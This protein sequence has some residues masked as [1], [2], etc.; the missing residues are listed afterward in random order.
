MTAT[1]TPHGANTARPTAARTPKITAPN[2]PM[3]NPLIG[4]QRAFVG[5]VVLTCGCGKFRNIAGMVLHRCPSIKRRKSRRYF[6]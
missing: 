2:M 6:E 3:N 5:C 4:D 1:T